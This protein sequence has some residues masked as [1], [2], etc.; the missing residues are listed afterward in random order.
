MKLHNGCDEWYNNF[1]RFLRISYVDCCSQSLNHQIHTHKYTLAPAPY[2]FSP[3]HSLSLS[4]LLHA[5]EVHLGAAVIAAVA[6]AAPNLLHF[7]QSYFHQ[8]FY[9]GAFRYT[10]LMLCIHK[11]INYIESLFSSLSSLN[12][13]PVDEC[14]RRVGVC[15]Y[16][17]YK[18]A[19]WQCLCCIYCFAKCSWVKEEIAI[20]TLAFQ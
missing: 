13:H 19:V 15:V 10:S 7:I 18:C 20:R 2:F 6:A 11:A 9:R 1:G 4:S 17:I 16:W 5:P 3:S 8:W 14:K 12:S